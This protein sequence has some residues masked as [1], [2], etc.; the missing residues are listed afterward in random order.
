MILDVINSIGRLLLT[1]IVIYKI[2]SFRETMNLLERAG[3]GAM[4]GGSFLTIALIW[5]NDGP[6]QGWAVT[7][8]TFGAI[9]F[10]GGRTWRDMQHQRNNARSVRQA[11]GWL[12]DRGKL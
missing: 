7:T 9:A 12:R 4:G 3:L 2:T 11:T 10:L 6:F 5:D 1:A 8:L